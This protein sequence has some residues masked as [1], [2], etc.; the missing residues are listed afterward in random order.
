MYSI[1]STRNL[2]DDR[3]RRHLS[4]HKWFTSK[5]KDWVIVFLENYVD[6][7]LAHKRKLHIKS[8]KSRRMVESLVSNGKCWFSA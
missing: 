2:P 3:L 4:D 1:G 5:A 7:S 6:Y 8:W